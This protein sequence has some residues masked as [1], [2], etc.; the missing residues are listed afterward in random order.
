[1]GE[2]DSA[3]QEDYLAWQQF[4]QLSNQ[5]KRGNGLGPLGCKA[6]AAPIAFP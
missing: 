5:A 6:E 1:M 2:P 4:R 3:M